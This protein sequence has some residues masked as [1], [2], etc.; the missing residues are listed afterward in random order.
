MKEKQVKNPMSILERLW[1]WVQQR[2]HSA[3]LTPEQQLETIERLG[4]DPS[5]VLWGSVHVSRGPK[6]GKPYLVSY[7]TF[8]TEGLD[9][10][11]GDNA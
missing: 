1:S 5:T 3:K 7:T 9:A 4:V 6:T 2:K 11:D 10:L 8:T